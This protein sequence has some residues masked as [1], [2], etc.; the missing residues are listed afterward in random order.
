M[1]D[2]FYHAEAQRRREDKE[3][4]ISAYP[5]SSLDSGTPFY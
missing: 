2:D 3:F 4:E 1:R 5:I